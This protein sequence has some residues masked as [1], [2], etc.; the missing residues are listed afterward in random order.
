MLLHLCF[1]LGPEQPNTD[2]EINSTAI[3]VDV[4][5]QIARYFLSKFCVTFTRIALSNVADTPCIV[6]VL[7]SHTSPIIL[8]HVEED[9]TY[10]Y[11]ATV[12]NTAVST[13]PPS[14]TATVRTNTSGRYS[15]GCNSINCN[16]LAYLLC[17][18]VS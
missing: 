4:S 10:E 16:K 5:V 15:L 12:N 8:T 7:C 1:A 6:T 17:A 14:P 3:Q 11:F 13:G 2:H 18:V 9:A